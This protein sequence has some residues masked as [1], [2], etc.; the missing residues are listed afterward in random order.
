MTALMVV[1][2]GGG[3]ELLDYMQS[4]LYW[5]A[6]GLTPTVESLMAELG[7]RPAEFVPDI[8]ALVRSE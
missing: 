8:T 1:L 5:Q 2:S 7:A 4:D 3:N 6:K